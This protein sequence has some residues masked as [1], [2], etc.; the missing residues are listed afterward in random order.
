MA[1]TDACVETVAAHWFYAGMAGT[2][3]GHGFWDWCESDGSGGWQ[4]FELMDSA[5]QQRYV[6]RSGGE[7]RYWTEVHQDGGCWWGMLYNFSLGQWEAKAHICGSVPYVFQDGWTMWESH[8]LMDQARVCPSLPSITAA[9]LLVLSGASWARL[10][11][12]TTGQ[13]GPYGLCWENGAY[14]FDTSQSLDWWQALTA[15]RRR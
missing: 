12:S 15:G 5:W 14:G 4:L 9:D 13:L 8:H 1:A 3:H 11:G 10:T 6:R 7:G 2:A